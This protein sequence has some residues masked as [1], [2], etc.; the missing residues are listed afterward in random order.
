[1]IIGCMRGFLRTKPFSRFMPK[2]VRASAVRK[3][4]VKVGSDCLMVSSKEKEQL[5]GEIYPR[6]KWPRYLAPYLV[7]GARPVPLLPL[8]WL[9]RS[10][11]K[12]NTTFR[13]KK[14]TRARA[15]CSYSASRNEIYLHFSLFS[16]CPP[17]FFYLSYFLSL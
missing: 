5:P 14:T 2:H 1:M 6:P 15:C 13:T 7:A 17:L 16:L 12:N 8:L 3:T 4:Y 11:Q 10:I 9:A